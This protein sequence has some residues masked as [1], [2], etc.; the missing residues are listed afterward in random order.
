MN[1]IQ[2]LLTQ[3][4]V[5]SMG[6][7]HIN[8]KIKKDQDLSVTVAAIF[9]AINGP[10]GITKEIVWP[11]PINKK[12]NIISFF[13][14]KITNAQW[15]KTVFSIHAELREKKAIGVRSMKGLDY[16]PTPEE[17]QKMVVERKIFIAS[18]TSTAE[19]EIKK[20]LEEEKRKKAEEL[21]AFQEKE[22]ARK[23][24]FESLTK[25]EK[26]FLAICKKDANLVND[27][28]EYI[29]KHKKLPFLKI[30]SL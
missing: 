17:Y 11:A 19:D 12:A 6:V 5:N 7:K 27:F 29:K 4:L 30:H 10:V 13:D 26:E 3:E 2:K 20:K 8:L 22:K 1:N 28:L 23:R 14:E 24:R 9:C 15:V 16:W 25:F 18:K 21:K